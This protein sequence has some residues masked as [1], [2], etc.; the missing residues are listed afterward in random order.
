M[1]TIVDQKQVT[2][3]K[4]LTGFVTWTGNSVE[5]EIHFGSLCLLFQ[6]KLC[7]SCLVKYFPEEKD[8]DST[9]PFKTRL[10][11]LNTSSTDIQFHAGYHLYRVAK[12]NHAH[13]LG[14]KY[15]IQNQKHSILT[16]L[17]RVKPDRKDILSVYAKKMTWSVLCR[18]WLVNALLSNNANSSCNVSS[19]A[20]EY[21]LCFASAEIILIHRAHPIFFHFP[22][23]ISNMVYWGNLCLQLF[24]SGGPYFSG[25]QRQLYPQIRMYSILQCIPII[26]LFINDSTFC[27]GNPALTFSSTGKRIQIIHNFPATNPAL[28]FANG[29]RDR[30]PGVEK[31]RNV[32]T[33]HSDISLCAIKSKSVPRTAHRSNGCTVIWISFEIDV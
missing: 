7:P 22:A 27:S 5:R 15:F 11:N 4:I 6:E 32:Y 9:A 8:P 3:L 1:K 33:P 29:L 2:R 13:G 30:S 31:H 16:I 14:S 24:N 19:P 20:V 25:G 17:C 18:W 12:G 26:F 21:T 10:H 28:P 23:P